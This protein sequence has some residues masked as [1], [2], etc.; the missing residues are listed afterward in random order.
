[1]ALEVQAL[2]RVFKYKGEKLDDIPGATLKEIA[3]HYSGVYPELLNT[4]PTFKGVEGNHEI[5]EFG[6]AKAGVKG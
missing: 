3:K 2:E 5:Y 1:M 6:T 4:A